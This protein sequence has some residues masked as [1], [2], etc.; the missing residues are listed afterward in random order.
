M[1]DAG[2]QKARAFELANPVSNTPSHI[3]EIP[4][5]WEWIS[6]ETAQASFCEHVLL[7]RDE[8]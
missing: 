8:S 3:D 7:E 1:S 4:V 2:Y 5:N 6:G